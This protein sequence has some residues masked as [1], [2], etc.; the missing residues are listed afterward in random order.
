MRYTYIWTVEE[1][2]MPVDWVKKGFSSKFLDWKMPE[3]CDDN[4]KSKKKKWIWF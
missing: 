4:N 2:S 3:C 1:Q